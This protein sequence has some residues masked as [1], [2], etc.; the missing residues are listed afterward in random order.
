MSEL[1]LDPEADT[2]G[3][4]VVRHVGKSLVK[5]MEMALTDVLWRLAIGRSASRSARFRSSAGDWNSGL[6][7]RQ[8]SG[9]NASTRALLNASV[10][11]PD[12]MGL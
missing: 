6:R 3:R 4:D 11:M 7:R 1:G 8:S 12:C 9:A 5:A 10:R 2:P